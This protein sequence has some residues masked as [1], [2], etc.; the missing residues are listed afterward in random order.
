MIPLRVIRTGKG[1]CFWRAK[2]P[3]FDNSAV[4]GLADVNILHLGFKNISQVVQF[5]HWGYVSAEDEAQIKLC[6]IGDTSIIRD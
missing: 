4:L 5:H 2:L 1:K 3:V 6:R